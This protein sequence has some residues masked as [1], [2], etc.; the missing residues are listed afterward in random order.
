MKPTLRQL[1]DERDLLNARVIQA[2]ILPGN[3]RRVLEIRE[4]AEKVQ[5]WID[6]LIAEVGT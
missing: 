2:E 3:E 4:R 6:K 1:Q 5:G